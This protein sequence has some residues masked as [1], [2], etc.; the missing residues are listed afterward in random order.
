MDVY[1]SITV[2]PS[3]RQFYSYTFAVNGSA[4]IIR[5]IQWCSWV[6]VPPNR[7]SRSPPISRRR[8][9][10]AGASRNVHVNWVQ[11]K[12]L[13]APRSIYVYNAPGIRGSKS[14]YPVLYLL[15]G[16]GDTETTWVAV[17]APILSSTI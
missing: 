13:G 6:I 1:W 11:S 4:N 10:S 3:I 15:H 16:S 5:G 17:G 8:M 14:T 9:T 2:G 7:C 12:S